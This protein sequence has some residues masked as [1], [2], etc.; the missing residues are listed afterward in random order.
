MYFSVTATQ[1]RAQKIFI[2]GFIQLHMVVIS[3]V[4]GEH[5]L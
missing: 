3:T 2:R 5:S 1:W 4:F